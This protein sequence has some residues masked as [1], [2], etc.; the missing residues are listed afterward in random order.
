MI[1]EIYSSHSKNLE[2]SEWETNLPDAL[3]SVCSILNTTIKI[4]TNE[5]S[6]S[7]NQ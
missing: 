2:K 1:I 6:F 7:F 5:R 3:H 4:T